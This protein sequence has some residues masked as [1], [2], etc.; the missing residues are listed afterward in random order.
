MPALITASAQTTIAGEWS[1]R[2]ATQPG[3]GWDAGDDR[4]GDLVRAGVEVGI[5]QAL[6]VA[7]ERRHCPNMF[8]TTRAKRVG[9]VPSNSVRS[10]ASGWEVGD[11]IGRSV[12]LPQSV[13]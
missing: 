1:S 3:A 7:A 5:R 13:P 10:K 6:A 2:Y 11:V 12:I 4:V 9:T 8:R